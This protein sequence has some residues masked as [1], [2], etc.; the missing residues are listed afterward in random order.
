MRNIDPDYAYCQGLVREGD[1]DRFLADLFAPAEARPHLH[2]LQ[3][4]N[5]EIESIRNRVTEQLKD[6]AD[7][8]AQGRMVSV[9]EGGYALSALGRSAAAHLRVLAGL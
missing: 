8:H 4:F 1:K 9:L 2:A 3:A 7:R 5:F 6:L